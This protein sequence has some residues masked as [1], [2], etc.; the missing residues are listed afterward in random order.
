[1]LRRTVI[2]GGAFGR[3]VS[4]FVGIHSS[5]IGLIQTALLPQNVIVEVTCVV[6]F[7]FFLSFLVGRS[8]DFVHRIKRTTVFLAVGQFG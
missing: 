6:S 5:M 2:R 1:M 7:L 3:T 4:D 8:S